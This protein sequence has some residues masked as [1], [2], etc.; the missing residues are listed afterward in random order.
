[1]KN[2]LSAVQAMFAAAMILACCWVIARIIGPEAPCLMS[3]DQLRNKVAA[4]RALGLSG[5][6]YEIEF[7]YR[8]GA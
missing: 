2:L 6:K 3:D 5:A 4:D 7:R 1:M 8:F